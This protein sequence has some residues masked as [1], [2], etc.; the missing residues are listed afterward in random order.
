MENSQKMVI[1]K[2]VCCLGNSLQHTHINEKGVSSAWLCLSCCITA[3]AGL[4]WLAS[5]VACRPSWRRFAVT[6]DPWNL[7]TV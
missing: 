3:F 6:A 2:I 7:I 4:K 5:V 1:F